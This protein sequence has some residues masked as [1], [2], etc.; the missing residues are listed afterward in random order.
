MND[1]RTDLPVIDDTDHGI[2]YSIYTGGT[3]IYI[4]GNTRNSSDVYVPCYWM[5][6]TRTDLPVIDDAYDG[7]AMSLFIN[8]E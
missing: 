5:N 2:A 6:D 8:E 3:D 1:T 7:G 4:A